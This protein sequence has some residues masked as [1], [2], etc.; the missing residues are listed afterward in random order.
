MTARTIHNIGSYLVDDITGDEVFSCRAGSQRDKEISA[1][2]LRNYFGGDIAAPNVRT[3]LGAH[4]TKVSEFPNAE[5]DMRPGDTVTG[6]Q[7]G[8]NV[9]FSHAQIWFS[10]L[11]PYTVAAL[12]TPGY[13]GMEAYVVDGAEGQG[14]SDRVVGGG[15]TTYKVWFNGKSWTITG[16]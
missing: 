14:W 2:K 8:Q 4:A 1:R 6:L 16:R 11:K 9:N 7:N 13:A 15:E 3:E 5:H 10:Q 12:P